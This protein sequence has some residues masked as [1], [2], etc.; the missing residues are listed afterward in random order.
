MSEDPKDYRGMSV[1]NCCHNRWASC[2]D[3]DLGM[4]CTECWKYLEEV[5]RRL[6]T[7]EEDKKIE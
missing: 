4:V 6:R 2:T 3:P 5:A 1:C 7:I